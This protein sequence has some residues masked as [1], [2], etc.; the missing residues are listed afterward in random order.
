METIGRPETSVWNCNYSLRYNTQERS[1]HIIH[2][3]ASNH[4]LVLCVLS[5]LYVARGVNSLFSVG[6][7]SLR[8][9]AKIEGNLHF[10]C[11]PYREKVN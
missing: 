2:D 1:S 4:S 6:N 8:D 9:R 5:L 3:E 10:S 7:D 11:Y